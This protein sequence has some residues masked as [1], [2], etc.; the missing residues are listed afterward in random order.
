MAESK[1]LQALFQVAA[2][3]PANATE[4]N[5]KF[6]K[7]G[8]SVDKLTAS[9]LKVVEGSK[10]FGK[11]ST[12]TSDMAERKTEDSAQGKYIR[13]EYWSQVLGTFSQALGKTIGQFAS[14]A[15][16][17]QNFQVSLTNLSYR[18]LNPGQ[19]MNQMYDQGGLIKLQQKMNKEFGTP[20]QGVQTDE[21]L[22]GAD[23]FLRYGKLRNQTQGK[24]GLDN[25]EKTIQIGK[26]ASRTRGLD[27][28]Q[29]TETALKYNVAGVPLAELMGFTKELANAAKI[30]AMSNKEILTLDSNIRQLAYGFK[31][32][33]TEIQRFGIDYMSVAGQLSLA[34][35]NAPDLMGKMNQYQTGSMPGVLNALLLG[36]KH[37]DNQGNLEKTKS[38]A[39]N[40]QS[41]LSTIDPILR[42]MMFEQMKGSQG[43]GGDYKMEDLEV[44]ARTG[45]K[46]DGGDDPKKMMALTAKNTGVLVTSADHFG[47]LLGT[48]NTTAITVGQEI[49]KT[50]DTQFTKYGPGLLNGIIKLGDYFKDHLFQLSGVLF[51][52]GGGLTGALGIAFRAAFLP[53]AAKATAATVLTEAGSSVTALAAADAAL[54]PGIT[55]ASGLGALTVGGLGTAGIATGLLYKKLFK[56]IGEE[57]AAESALIV[58]SSKNDVLQSLKKKINM[59]HAAGDIEKEQIYRQTFQKLFHVPEEELKKVHE[60]LN[61]EASKMW[62]PGEQTKESIAVLDKLRAPPISSTTAV[63]GQRPIEAFRDILEAKFGI[64]AGSMMM[65]SDGSL[66]Q[67]PHGQGLKLDVPGSKNSPEQMLQSVLFARSLNTNSQAKIEYWPTWARM[68]NKE[69]LLKERFGDSYNESTKHLFRPG[70]I[71]ANGLDNFTGIHADLDIDKNMTTEQMLAQGKGLMSQTE[72]AKM[73]IPNYGVSLEKGSEAGWSKAAL[74]S[75]EAGKADITQTGSAAETATQ[76]AAAAGT[77]QL[78]HDEIVNNSIQ[79][80]SKAILEFLQGKSTPGPRPFSELHAKA[81]NLVSG[82]SFINGVLAVAGVR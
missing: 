32:S 30:G 70:N 16:Q 24:E 19:Q 31:M 63:A 21:M 60:E 45:E 47:G 69:A 27:F 20:W 65:N 44:L 75:V 59:A 74:G 17:A 53:A 40:F 10:E 52:L 23:Q 54:T 42:P 51:A 66:R 22:F 1:N 5:N 46:Q 56:E 41:L 29:G 73:E 72:S 62:T 81:N 28:E 25:I 43:F 39:L 49:L 48:L 77:K 33:G 36:L 64:H 55:L 7:L 37:G 78:V 71:G 11:N 18:M 82:G 67:G 12:N 8:G 4:L 3:D 61:P 76:K 34:G 50:I 58:G 2:I 38:G 15:L 57:E 14:L 9:L 35:G 6:D 80:L 26:V 68:T 79:E 13:A